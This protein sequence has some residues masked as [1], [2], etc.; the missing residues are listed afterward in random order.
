MN[1]IFQGTMDQS[2]VLSNM[3][4]GSKVNILTDADLTLAFFIPSSTTNPKVGD[5]APSEAL[6]APGGT[7]RVP[8]SRVLIEATSTADLLITLAND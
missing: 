7:V 8:S 3:P 4:V 5:F 2:K 6:E 1:V